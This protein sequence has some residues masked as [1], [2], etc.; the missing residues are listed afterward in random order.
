M[1]NNQPL[2][3]LSALTTPPIS[4]EVPDVRAKVS[5]A[6]FW[7]GDNGRAG[8]LGLTALI[9]LTVAYAECD[10]IGPVIGASGLPIPG[11]LY[12]EAADDLYLNRPMATSRSTRQRRRRRPRQP[13][14]L[15]AG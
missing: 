15:L 2:G 9:N 8:V 10:D 6:G 7:T 1:L 11:S 4:R 5:L 13:H 12:V 14:P 3:Q